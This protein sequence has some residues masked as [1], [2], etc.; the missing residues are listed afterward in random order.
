MPPLHG[1]LDLHDGVAVVVVA[2]TL[3]LWSLLARLRERIRHDRR[4]KDETGG[5]NPAEDWAERGGGTAS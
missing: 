3:A 4:A 2:A 1:T 5:G